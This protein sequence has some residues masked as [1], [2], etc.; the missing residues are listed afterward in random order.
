MTAA[1]DAEPGRVATVDVTIVVI[2]NANAP[3]FLE[4]QYQ[5]TMSQDTP[6]GEAII[7]V[8]ATDGDGVGIVLQ[9][10]RYCQGR[11][12]LKYSFSSSLS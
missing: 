7:G 11:H 1:D 12:E 10:I 3:K 8:N 5:K 9:S 2:R 4:N 6:L